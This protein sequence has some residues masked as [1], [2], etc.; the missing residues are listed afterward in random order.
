[1]QERVA[2]L[3]FSW[4][5]SLWLVNA[6]YFSHGNFT[7]FTMGVYH[8]LTPRVYESLLDFTAETERE[9]AALKPQDRID[10]QSFIWVVGK[11]RVEDEAGI[12]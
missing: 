11:C 9:I 1:L 12:E 10:V 7:R 5:R 3:S 4:Y 6:P 2:A 8:L